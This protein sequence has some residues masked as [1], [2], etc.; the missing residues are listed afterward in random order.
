MN[1]DDVKIGQWYLE[2]Q[3]EDSDG[4]PIKSNY[5]RIQDISVDRTKIKIV[6][7]QDY[8]NGREGHQIYNINCLKSLKKWKPNIIQRFFGFI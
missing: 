1:P 4:F 7:E 3:K 2:S 8:R 6:W 5:F